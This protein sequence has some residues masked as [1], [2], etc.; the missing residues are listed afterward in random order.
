MLQIL[1]QIEA[2]GETDKEVPQWL[3]ME[4]FELRSELEDIQEEE[5]I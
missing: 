4:V 5:E 3:M 1:A 2:L